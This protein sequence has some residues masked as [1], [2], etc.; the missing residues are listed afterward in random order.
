MH[1][2]KRSLVVLVAIL[3]V[4]GAPTA[5]AQPVPDSRPDAISDVGPK[6]DSPEG[7]EMAPDRV[8][9]RWRDDGAAAAVSR[10]LGLRQLVTLDSG[11]TQVLGTGGRA[12]A[13]VVS[14]LRRQPAVA[15]AEPDY[16]VHVDAGEVAVNDA[17][18]HQ[19]YAL[20]R[21]NV[22]E[23]W[24]ITTG[25][26]NLIAVLDTGVW[27]AHPDLAGRIAPGYDFVNGDADPADDNAH[28]TWVSGILAARAN[29]GYGVAGITWTD[30]ILPVKVMDQNGSGY[31]SVLATGIR[32]AADQ[33]ASVINM[34]IGGYGDSTALREAIEYAW[35]KNV[36]MVAAAGNHRR[37]EQT[38]P[39][40]Y[41]QVISVSATQADDEFTN[42]SSYGAAV[43]VSAPGA[44]IMTT[45][46]DRRVVT[47]CAYDGSHI[48]I[49]GTSFSTPNTA[50]VAALLRAA[51]PLWTNQ[52]VM[53]RIISS[54]DDLGYPGWDMRYGYGRVN[55]M[56]ALGGSTTPP[57]SSP[58]DSL[59]G[60]NTFASASLMPVN[61]WFYPSI[62]P[63]GD[64]DFLAFT[65]P[66]AG[67]L[68]I[69]VS[70]VIDTLR[71]PKSSLPIDPMLQVYSA[72]GSLL[73]S[74]DDPSDSATI[75]RASIQV[76]GSTRIVVR[77]NNWFPNGNRQ[78]Y[79]VETGFVDNVAPLL[80]GRSPSSG[81]TDVAVDSAATVTF[82]EAV[83]GVSA[84]TFQLR[85][86]VGS[87][88]P[89]T[90]TYDPAAA[91]A[92][93]RPSST[94]LGQATYTLSLSTAIKDA[95]GN[96]LAAQAWAF[97][98]GPA[99]ARLAGSDR[100]AT[101]ALVSATGFA[102]GVPVAYLATG[103][104]FPDAL[105]AG[106]VAARAGGPILLVTRDAIPS[107]TAGELS[108]L[109]P[110]RI[111]VLGGSGAVGD[112]VLAAARGYATGGSVTRLAGVDRYATAAAVSA[113]AFAPGIPV[114]YVATGANFPDALAAGPVAARNGGPILLVTRDGIPAAT[115]AE[116]RRLRP[117]GIVV[118]GGTGAV[119]D[120]VLAGLRPSA[121][122]GT[123]IRLAG[124]SRYA[125]AAAI[126]ASEWA[127][128]EP[129]TAFLATGLTFADA[130]AA[131]PLAG[132]TGS[133]LLLTDPSHLS[134]PTRVE[135]DRLAP[136]N[137]VILGGIG[138]LSDQIRIDVLAMAP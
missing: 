94:L 44:S 17:L 71:V 26:S 136:P 130:L 81:A 2:L 123:V 116:L 70:P 110:V 45:N 72:S 96:S 14:D 29:D 21:M 128:G 124:A 6:T 117:A 34:S 43:D 12:V 67:R 89:A 114:A 86:S 18:T 10:G 85:N 51:N 97:T 24:S 5:A 112:G 127:A 61:T 9:V 35:S 109:R 62:H 107:A 90:V 100:Y 31:T 125:T 11:V 75:E 111:V 74:V 23:A 60:N 77:V 65:T 92:T 4:A 52:Q 78:G 38:Y 135:L 56:R 47:S 88:V 79:R 106:P 48:T 76:S 73:M 30:R 82:S 49:S 16:V 133:P 13:D 20:D 101:A 98:T 108:R 41:P 59:E 39:A 46:C 1:S 19:Q 28:G 87:V 22:R 66:R 37:V 132:I 91:R 93:L 103:L 54:S 118:L 7:L 121:T 36:V 64:V 137:V 15:W 105:A 33:G 102:P 50:G 25:G 68:D 8:V 83:S 84:S 80:A 122:S 95:G 119:G 55:A 57:P 3:A 99:L 27:A 40:S 131:A 104:N 138:A 63:A 126:S 115:A 129:S 113:S 53:S 42:W 134:D 69:A 32:W 120:G 58:G